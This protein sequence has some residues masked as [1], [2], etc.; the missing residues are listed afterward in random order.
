MY[1]E[2]SSAHVID[3]YRLTNNNCTTMVSD[4]LNESGSAALKGIGFQQTSNFGT[5][6]TVPIVNRFVFPKSMQKHLTRISQ[7]GGVVYKTR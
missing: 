1:Y 3:E 7:S 2:N 4:V 5:W 6:T